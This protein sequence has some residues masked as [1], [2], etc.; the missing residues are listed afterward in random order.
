MFLAIDWTI[1]VP[2]LPLDCHVGDNRF[3]N[4]ASESVKY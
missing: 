1:E 4:S 2:R 3:T